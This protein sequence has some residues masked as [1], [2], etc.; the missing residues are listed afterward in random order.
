MC[1][2]TYIKIVSAPG[3][4]VEP[5]DLEAGHPKARREFGE[6]GLEKLGTWRLMG[7]AQTRGR[8]QKVDP[9]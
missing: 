9:T 7:L 5:E 2:Y 3:T 1:I 6:L 8:I 4:K